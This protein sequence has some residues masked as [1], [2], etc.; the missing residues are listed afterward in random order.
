MV[1]WHQANYSKG[2]VVVRGLV[3]CE[4]VKVTFIQTL[5][6]E[7]F[8]NCSNTVG[9]TVFVRTYDSLLISD[10]ICIDKYH[11]QIKCAQLLHTT[12]RI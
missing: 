4:H 2:F 5:L 9:F 1:G 10:S 3:I 11:I 8:S 12:C 6:V 7:L